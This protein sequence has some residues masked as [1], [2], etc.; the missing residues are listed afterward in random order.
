MSQIIA[1][2]AD[3]VDYSRLLADHPTTTASRLDDY[4]RLVEDQVT[5]SSGTLV[6]FVGDNFM[7]VFPAAEKAMRGA[8][9]I[10]S[11]IELL[12]DELPSTEQMRFRMGLDCGEVVVT[13]DG[14]YVGDTLNI[15]ARIQAMAIPGGISVSGPVFHALD[16]PSLRFR[17]IGPKQLKNIPEAVQI[18]E[19]TDLPS[20]EESNRERPTAFAEPTLA[21]LPLHTEGIDGATAALGGAVMAE[22][23]RRL[24]QIPNLKLIDAA[25]SPE[26][27]LAAPSSN[28]AG[29]MLQS[30]MFVLGDQI[31]IYAQMLETGTI[32]IV[33]ADRW[34]A[35]RSGILALA[36][37]AANDVGR[38]VEIELIVGEPARI[39]NEYLDA[40]TLTWV[41]QGWYELTSAAKPGWMKSIELFR[42]LL[43]NESSRLLA[44][45]LLAYAHWMGAEFRFGDPAAELALAKEHAEAGIGLGDDTGLSHT[46]MGAICLDEGKPE[47]AVAVLEEAEILLRPTCD[48]TFGV[49][50]SIRRYMGQWE[51]AVDLAQKA[52][53]LTPMVKPWY[54][55]V[56]ASSYYVGQRYE[57]AA[58]LAERVLEFQPNNMEALLVLAASQSALGL[59]RR[60]HVTA[61]AV[62]ERFPTT[63]ASQW[64]ERTPYQDNE[65]ME[66]WQRDLAGAGLG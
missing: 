65:V 51:Q 38:A 9:S 4:K 25:T 33:W 47:E 53:D 31:R 2:N 32:N 62:K 27:D 60:A 11:S 1:L 34:E 66:R 20:G 24:A 56:L 63:S 28:G 40:E 30:G 3:I 58:A 57:D 45:G 59:D 37:Q 49:E 7:A 5:K 26:T 16:E 39:Y 14:Q 42:R 13:S 35:E 50:A 55:T 6:N 12:N 41:Y 21:L 48:V 46:V 23:A 22:I 44:H 29:Y 8:I 36:D 54:P 19:F 43:D 61:E 10:T 18:Y 17:S 52:M 64:L 15:A